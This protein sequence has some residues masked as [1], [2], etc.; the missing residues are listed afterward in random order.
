MSLS[1][2]YSARVCIDIYRVKVFVP[3]QKCESWYDWEFLH[4]CEKRYGQSSV[5]LGTARTRT[6]TRTNRCDGMDAMLMYSSLLLLV[7]R[8]IVMHPYVYVCAER[9]ASDTHLPIIPRYSL[10]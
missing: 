10:L 1:Y 9:N 2:V 5:E 4:T 3:I 6:R 8:V 7:A